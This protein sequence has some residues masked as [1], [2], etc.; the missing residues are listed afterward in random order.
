MRRVHPPHQ[1]P[2]GTLQRGFKTKAAAEAAAAPDGCYC[3]RARGVRVHASTKLPCRQQHH[4]RGTT[5]TE[6][7]LPPHLFLQLD[8]TSKQCKGKYVLGY[9]ALLVQWNVFARVTL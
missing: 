7:K 8:N 5:P 9:L 1:A 3:A 4:H 2:E 6:G